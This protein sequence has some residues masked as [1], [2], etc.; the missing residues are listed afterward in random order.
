MGWVGLRYRLVASVAGADGVDL[1][2][3]VSPGLIPGI[4]PPPRSLAARPPDEPTIWLNSASAFRP[5]SPWT[6]RS[7]Q[8][9]GEFLS[10]SRPS[11]SSSFP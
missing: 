2:G 7:K 4:C 6:S 9:P 5:R 3:L 1:A 8:K 11:G 10:H